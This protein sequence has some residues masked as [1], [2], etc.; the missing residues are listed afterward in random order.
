MVVYRDLTSI[1][2]CHLYDKIN[3]GYLSELKNVGFT[4]SITNPHV[5]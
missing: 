4:V 1:N 5:P 3:P 2:K